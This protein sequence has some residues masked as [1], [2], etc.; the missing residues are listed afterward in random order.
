MHAKDLAS[1]RSTVLAVPAAGMQKGRSVAE[2][3]V[4]PGHGHGHDVSMLREHTGWK[5]CYWLKPWLHDELQH[6]ALNHG[7]GVLRL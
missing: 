7:C 6:C 4:A 1:K 2:S 5:D 3:V